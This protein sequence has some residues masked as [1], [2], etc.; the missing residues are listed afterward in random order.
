MQEKKRLEVKINETNLNAPSNLF[1]FCL[2]SPESGG[3][4]KSLNDG[5]KWQ[6]TASSKPGEKKT[7]RLSMPNKSKRKIL[8]SLKEYS[9]STI[10]TK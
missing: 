8:R 2:I 6:C 4:C 1:K 9:I 3:K 10:A 5:C 7:K